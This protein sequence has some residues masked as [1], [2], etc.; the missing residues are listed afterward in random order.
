MVFVY[1]WSWGRGGLVGGR[2]MHVWSE[3]KAALV[4][5]VTA[6]MNDELCSLPVCVQCRRPLRLLLKLPL[7]SRLPQSHLL[8]K[9]SNAIFLMP[10]AL[11]L[12]SKNSYRLQN[13]THVW[14]EKADFREQLNVS[15][16]VA[17]KSAHLGH[18]GLCLWGTLFDW[19][20]LYNHL[21]DNTKFPLT[22]VAALLLIIISLW[23]VAVMVMND[24]ETVRCVFG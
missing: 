18:L 16:H 1:V 12:T 2:D 10:F 17:L 6:N 15:N 4:L 24:G 11:S 14:K 22:H 7:Q 13:G 3:D 5:L 8:K 19:F 9:V 20:R 23:M 21:K